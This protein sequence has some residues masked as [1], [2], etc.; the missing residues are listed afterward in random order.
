M[1]KAKHYIYIYIHIVLICRAPG[2]PLYIKAKHFSNVYCNIGLQGPFY[3][4][5]QYTFWGFPLI[6]LGFPWCFARGSSYNVFF[7]KTGAV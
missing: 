1:Y 7:K 6:S 2:P 3:V 4:L 5:K